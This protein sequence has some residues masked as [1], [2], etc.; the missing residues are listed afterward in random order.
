MINGKHHLDTG[1]WHNKIPPNIARQRRITLLQ[2]VGILEHKYDELVKRLK[3][4]Q[5]NM[6]R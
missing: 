1:D 3:N 2:R 4:I 6:P 5:T